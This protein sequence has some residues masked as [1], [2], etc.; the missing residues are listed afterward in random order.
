MHHRLAHPSP[1]SSSPPLRAAEFKAVE[2]LLPDTNLVGTS[3]VEYNR[4]GIRIVVVQSGRV[5]R[6]DIQTLLINIVV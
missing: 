2:A 6:F 5:G 1:P 3:R 4:H